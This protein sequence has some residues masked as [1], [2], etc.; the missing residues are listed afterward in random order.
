MLN[1]S[2][3]YLGGADHCGSQEVKVCF[4][5]TKNTHQFCKSLENKIFVNVCF[6]TTKKPFSRFLTS[7][8]FLKP[9]KRPRANPQEEGALIC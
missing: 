2:T 6:S 3:S 7:F 9:Y 4:S 5:T 8:D 1:C